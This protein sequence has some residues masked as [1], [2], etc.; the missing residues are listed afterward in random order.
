VP[1]NRTGPARRLHISYLR[2]GKRTFQNTWQCRQCEMWVHQLVHGGVVD[3]PT[4]DMYQR[5][6]MLATHPSDQECC[7]QGTE[8]ARP[9]LLTV[10]RRHAQGAHVQAH[11]HAPVLAYAQRH[12]DHAAY[13]SRVLSLLHACEQ[14]L[15]V[16]V[17]VLEVVWHPVVVRELH[18]QPSHSRERGVPPLDERVIRLDTRLGLA[19]G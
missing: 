19:H 15:Y 11:R 4:R 9:H 1:W 6:D 18:T 17:L 8:Q 5:L 7:S 3:A 10:L 16:M 13:V 14:Q 2:F 12:A